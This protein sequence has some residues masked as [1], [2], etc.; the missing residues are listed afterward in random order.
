MLLFS[1]DLVLI[2]DFIL[3]K[4]DSLMHALSRVIAMDPG[5]RRVILVVKFQ[6]QVVLSPPPSYGLNILK[7]L[8]VLGLPCPP[9]QRGH[10][11]KDVLLILILKSEIFKFFKFMWG[12]LLHLHLP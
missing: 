9:I 11:L 7:P 2:P 4:F 3:L 6:L 8:T 1:V 10:I 12:I 5:L